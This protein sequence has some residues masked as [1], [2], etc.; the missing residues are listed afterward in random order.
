VRAFTLAE[1]AITVAVI[2]IL[3]VLAVAGYRRLVAAERAGEARDIVLR[4]GVAQEQYAA[5]GMGYANIS[6][7]LDATYPAATPGAFRTQW[8]APCGDR[9]RSG[10]EWAML[11]LR[12]TE[13]VLFGYATVAGF[14]LEQPRPK[15]VMVGAHL[16]TFGEADRAPATDWWLVAAK[17][18]TDGDGTPCHLFLSSFDKRQMIVDGEGE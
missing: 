2:G 15:T 13:P 7:D 14:A 11:D 16:V 17:G 1:L 6:T 4:I 10:M 8:G 5:K 12:V 3:A 9:C 18:D